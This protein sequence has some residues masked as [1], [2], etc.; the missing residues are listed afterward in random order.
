MTSAVERDGVE[1]WIIFSL[2][3][4]IALP[5]NYKSIKLKWMVTSFFLSGEVNV[6]LS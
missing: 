4:P 1:E 3:S 2:L 5:L 6:H